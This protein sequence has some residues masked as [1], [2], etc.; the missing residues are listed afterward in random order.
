MT[1][2][3]RLITSVDISTSVEIYLVSDRNIGAYF[4]LVKLKAAILLSTVV[5]SKK[6]RQVILLS[7]LALATCLN[8]S[9]SSQPPTLI[10]FCL[11]KV[12]VSWCLLLKSS[13]S[14]GSTLAPTK[15]LKER[16]SKTTQEP[17]DVAV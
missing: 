3:T 10:L 7:R 6:K 2:T 14:S 4:L 1:H 12:S 15:G 8:R 16:G 11:A 5:K 9:L 13:N 17:Q